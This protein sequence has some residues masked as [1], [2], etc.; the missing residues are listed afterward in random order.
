VWGRLRGMAHAGLDGNRNCR[1]MALQ[2]QPTQLRIADVVARPP[3]TPPAEYLPEVAYVGA[4][5]IRIAWP[6]IL[7][8][9][10]YEHSGGVEV[11]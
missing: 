11:P 2:M 3:E 10:T 1:I 8:T 9:S 5:A 4:G 6:R 7:P